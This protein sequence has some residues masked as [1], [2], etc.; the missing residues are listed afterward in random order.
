MISRGS[1][2]AVGILTMAFFSATTIN[3]ECYSRW[4]VS[5]WTC[6]CCCWCCCGHPWRP[7]DTITTDYRPLSPLNFKKLLTATSQDR[8]CTYIGLLMRKASFRWSHSEQ[9]YMM[10]TQST[11]PPI[12]CV[13]ERLMRTNQARKTI[14]MMTTTPALLTR[15]FETRTS[16]ADEKEQS[17][18]HS[19]VL[20]ESNP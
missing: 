12:L 15:G 1:S 3:H 17:H 4:S 9:Y 11:K 18:L 16:H 8:T 6:C 7:Q 20:P 13:F 2:R 14:M 5:C 19:K 10:F